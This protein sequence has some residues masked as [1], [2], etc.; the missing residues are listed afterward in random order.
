MNTKGYRIK[1]VV[2]LWFFRNPNEQSNKHLQHQASLTEIEQTNL[3]EEIIHKSYSI[4]E[5]K[6]RWHITQQKGSAQIKNKYLRIKKKGIPEALRLLVQVSTGSGSYQWQLKTQKEKWSRYKCGRRLT[7]GT[8]V[9]E[10]T[11][12]PTLLRTLNSSKYIP[13]KKARVRFLQL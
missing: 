12:L 7:L 5:K 9:S 10:R 6:T 4:I 3:N 8:A 13:L 1:L 11:R 2:V